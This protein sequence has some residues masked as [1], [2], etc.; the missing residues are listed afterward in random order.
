MMTKI[1]I[2]AED[3]KDE[4]VLLT[5]ELKAKE[6][7]VEIWSVPE[8]DVT[9]QLEADLISKWKKNQEVA[10]PDSA[11]QMDRPLSISENILPDEIKVLSG[12]DILR[13]AR[14]EWPVTVLSYKLHDLYENELG[15][16][17]AKVDSMSAFS[18]DVFN[19]LKG[20]WNKVQG[21]IRDRSLMRDHSESLRATT[22]GLFDSMKEMRSALDKE[23]R[24][25]SAELKKTFI[26]KLEAVE[27][28][29]E[30]GR[31]GKLFDELKSIQNEFKDSK[32]TK[33][34]RSQIWNR[35]DA[36]FKI[37]KEKKYG[38]NANK[39]N[40]SSDRL[41]KRYDGL[42]NAMDKMD[43]SI[44]RD[45]KDLSFQNNRINNADGQLEAQ[46]R[47]A[48]LAMIQERIRS[49]EEKYDDMKK[50]KAE[51]DAKLAAQEQRKAKK[52]VE[53]EIK[54]KI[55]NKIKSDQAS[56]EQDKDKLTALGAALT[57]AKTA[58]PVTSKNNDKVSVVK[59]EV[60]DQ[61]PAPDAEVTTP[62]MAKTE[63]PSMSESIVN[64]TQGAIIKTDTSNTV[65]SEVQ[66]DSF[67]YAVDTAIAVN[68]IDISLSEEE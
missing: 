55:A 21:Q 10:L 38:P 25:A 64:S 45:K 39:N 35:L 42:L 1:V 53:K 32:F 4:K 11:I 23:F 57:T 34:D 44:Q 13:R 52:E 54:Q 36:A 24:G 20:F 47:E 22:N 62:L 3:A 26:E 37:V 8:K 41:Q 12:S 16:I 56:R 28:Q 14:T 43:R 7:K 46:L 59:D 67:K 29:V 49:K 17:K 9:D 51:L 50:T 48:K 33:D 63:T 66:D 15:E 65:K 19:E 61:I 40:N 68:K 31:L 58:L 18:S 2:W 6:N 5:L 27:S 30:N 60:Q